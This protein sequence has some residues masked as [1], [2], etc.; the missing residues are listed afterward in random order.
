MVTP[1]SWIYVV[2]WGQR[3][4]QMLCKSFAYDIERYF[5]RVVD[6]IWS[7]VVSETKTKWNVYCVARQ[8]HDS[9]YVPALYQANL[10]S[11]RRA[12]HPSRRVSSHFPLQQ[13]EVWK[14]KWSVAQ[15]NLKPFLCTSQ[16][17][18]LLV[19]HTFSTIYQQPDSRMLESSSWILFYLN[20]PREIWTQLR[21]KQ[22]K[23]C[24]HLCYVNLL[25][26][27]VCRIFSDFEHYSNNKKCYCYEWKRLCSVGVAI[28][29][30]S[31]F[32]F[33]RVS[34]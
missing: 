4:W 20:L 15:N 30:R 21:N 17:F 6:S 22:E 12:C 34:Q 18:C 14:R 5:W 3:I 16:W 32:R 1:T 31:C 28:T 7:F 19:S 27:I 33:N 13:N 29:S 11:R 25:A 23:A 10:H 9:R 26:L 8:Y 24:S 2:D